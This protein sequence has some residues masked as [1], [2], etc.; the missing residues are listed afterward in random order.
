MIVVN[1]ALFRTNLLSACKEER[2]IKIAKAT[3]KVKSITLPLITSPKESSG[4]PWSAEVIPT[5][6]SGSEA[7]KEMAK[8]ATTNS[9]QLKNLAIRI[10]A[11][12]SHSPAKAR[13][14]Q[15]IKKIVM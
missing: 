10:S 9:R 13:K 7:P 15:E 14:T 4:M 2:L 11:L 8:K 1:K 12:T 6:K 5:N 3:A